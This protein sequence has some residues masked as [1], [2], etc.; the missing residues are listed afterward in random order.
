MAYAQELE[1]LLDSD[2]ESEEESSFREIH[3][4]YKLFEVMVVT[5]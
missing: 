1:N 4:S 5:Y 2:S 3:V